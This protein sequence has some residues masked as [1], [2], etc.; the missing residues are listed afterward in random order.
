M[1]NK[2]HL[3]YFTILQRVYLLRELTNN[4]DV[5]KRW[6]EYFDRLLNKENLKR[7]CII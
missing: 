5:K 1:C 7:S 2:Q 6:K 3:W 4:E